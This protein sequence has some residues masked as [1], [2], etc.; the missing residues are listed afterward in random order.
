MKNYL[1]IA[2]MTCP[3]PD[4]E[5]MLNE[6][7]FKFG[8][9]EHAETYQDAETIRDDMAKWRKPEHIVIFERAEIDALIVGGVHER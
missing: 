2:C 6:Q 3:L 8:T 1:V 9:H 5:I 4:A 7:P